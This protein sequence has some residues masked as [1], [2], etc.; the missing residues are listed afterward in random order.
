VQLIVR[1][2]ICKTTGAL[3]DRI[4]CEIRQSEK[5]LNILFINNIPG[6]AH[7]RKTL[8]FVIS[9]IPGK[10]R[11]KIKNWRGGVNARR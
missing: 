8:S 11:E 10:A 1:C 4:R 2:A 9:N 7:Y 6:K 5:R 3:P